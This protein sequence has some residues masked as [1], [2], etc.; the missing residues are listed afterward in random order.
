[1]DINLSRSDDSQ[2][3]VVTLTQHNVRWHKTCHWKF[4]NDEI[5]CAR[6]KIAKVRGTHISPLKGR[7]QGCSLVLVKLTKV[8]TAFLSRQSRENTDRSK[9]LENGK[10]AL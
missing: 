1:M 7:Q 8:C 2:F 6:R 10:R 3:I 4:S 5:A 9:C